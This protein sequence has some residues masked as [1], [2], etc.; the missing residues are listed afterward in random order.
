[1]IGVV[2]DER[3][4]SLLRDRFEVAGFPDDAPPLV[5]AAHHLALARALRDELQFRLFGFVV[6]S[7]WPGKPA[8]KEG[9]SGVAEA[10][11]L[12][13]GLRSIGKGSGLAVW[14][15]CLA[16]GEHAPSLVELFAGAD[17]Q[18]REQFDL[19]GVRFKGHPDLR[20]LMMPEDWEGFPLR[21][22]YPINT[23]CPPWR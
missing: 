8:K 20:R 23:P 6:A 2:H 19:V 7:H 18:E 14:R 17:W 16:A 22:D 12:A 10:F 9:E 1:M 21:R 15:L 4:V 11:E 3:V 5:G 13:Y